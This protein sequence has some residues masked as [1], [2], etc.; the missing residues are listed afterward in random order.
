[1]NEIA[2][3]QVHRSV[4][5]DSA[6]RHVQGSAAYIDDMK[7]PEG[8]LHAWVILSERAHARILSIDLAAVAAAPGVAAVITA[9]DVPGINDAAPI[10]KNEPL[11]A[12]DIVEHAGQ[13]IAIVAAH[14]MDQA[15]KAA[16]LAKIV[17]EDLPA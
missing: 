15:R 6:R 17:Y 10:G 1:M 16:G 8:L 7:E 5:H 2:R 13:A 14:S 11:L 9:G 4:A 12:E 3:T